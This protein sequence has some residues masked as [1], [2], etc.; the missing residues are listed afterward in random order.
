MFRQSAT[1]RG[2]WVKYT[3]LALLAAGGASAGLYL[4]GAWS[5]ASTP[6]DGPAPAEVQRFPLS[7]FDVRDQQEAPKLAADGGGVYL[8]WASQTGENERTLY[9]T[10][11]EGGAFAE[12][13]SLA[14]SGIFRTV[15]RSRG[16]T[17]T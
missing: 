6:K 11:R 9:L 4:S 5:G 8:A 17:V 12:P 2:G 1:G 7:T 16:Q 14:T 13:R 3:F 15:S 10:R